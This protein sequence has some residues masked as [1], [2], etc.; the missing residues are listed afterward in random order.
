MLSLKRT[1]TG[2]K[3]YDLETF[4]IY[5]RDRKYS[6]VRGLGKGIG[7]QPDGPAFGHV[8]NMLNIKQ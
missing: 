3:V 7:N 1:N 6:K 8:W 4:Y 5:S 2:K